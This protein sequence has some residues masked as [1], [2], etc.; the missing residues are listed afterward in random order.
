MKN[1]SA[2]VAELADALDSGSSVQK[3][4][5]FKSSQPHYEGD[6]PVAFLVLSF[7][8]QGQLPRVAGPEDEPGDDEDDL[9]GG[10]E[11][12]DLCDHAPEDVNDVN[13]R[14]RRRATDG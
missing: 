10:V 2:A 14:Q 5:R 12:V 9:D 4:W 8:R 7:R 13:G 1:Q 6:Q 3:T 11:Q